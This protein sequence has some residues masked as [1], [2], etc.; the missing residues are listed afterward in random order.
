VILR[1]LTPAWHATSVEGVDPQRL[2]RDGIRGVVL[3]LDN[4][5]VAWNASAPTEAVRQWV[6]R[7]RRAGLKACIVSNNFRDRP[8]AIAE[9]LGIPVVRAG[10]ET[11]SVGVSEGDDHH[12][13]P[14]PPDRADW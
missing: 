1:W 12:G 3:D 6:G 14:R 2:V 5:V 13:D 9:A 10:G 4:T 7:L 8:R 11:D